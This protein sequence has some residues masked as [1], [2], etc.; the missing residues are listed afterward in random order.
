VVCADRLWLLEKEWVGR[1]ATPEVVE[2]CGGGDLAAHGRHLEFLT[3]AVEAWRRH[4]GSVT[5]FQC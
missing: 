1:E 3:E 2:V 4:Q 5:D